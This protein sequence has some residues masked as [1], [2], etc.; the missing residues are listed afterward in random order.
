MVYPP[1]RPRPPHPWRAAHSTL[2]RGVTPYDA[3]CHCPPGSTP[4]TILDAIRDPRLFSPWFQPPKNWATWQVVLKALFGLPMTPREVDVF[5]RFTGRTTPPT[6]PAR[7]AWLIVGRRGG[8][9]RIAALIAIFLAC[10]RNYTHILAP[11]EKGVV[12]VLAADRKQARVILGYVRALL[13]EVPMLASMVAHRSAEAIHLTNRITIE[14]HT[15]N[16][17]AVRGY[18]VVAA[19]LDEVA[20]WYG[21]ESLNPDTEILTALRP[22]MLTVR[23]PLLLGISSPYAR[24]GVLWEAYRNHFGQDGDEVLVW[25]AATRDMNPSIP[26]RF[27]A[28][29]VEKDPTSARA[30]YLAEFRT[31]IESFLSR[32]TIE[33]CVT[34]GRIEVPP[35]SGVRHVGFVDLSGAADHAMAL[36]I[37]HEAGDRVGLNLVRERRSPVLSRGRRAGVRRAVEAV[38][39]H[40]GPGGPLCGGM[41]E[42][43]LPH[44]RDRLRARRPRAL[45]LVSR[46]APL[47]LES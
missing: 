5:S 42:G 10:F 14:V 44:A 47:A 3:L 13:D 15:A 17:R 6:S 32:E 31:D 27:V 25:Q 1:K 24:R 29:Q 11:G 46:P 22:A 9:S 40:P 37:A 20:F 26:E 36:A 7:E 19:I 33:A 23:E 2:N 16:Y 38:S 41:A 28:R 4:V 21:E 8:K 43:A 39:H 45:G 35:I 34:P 18:T 30:E 12:M